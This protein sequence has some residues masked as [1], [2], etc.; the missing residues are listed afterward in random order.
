MLFATPA[1]AANNSAE[2]R[3]QLAAA[4]QAN[5]QHAVLELARRITSDTPKDSVTWEKLIRAGIALSEFDR[6]L[7][8][9]DEWERAVTP[10]P[11]VIE[12]LRG[13]ICLQNKDDAG[14]E[15]HWRNFVSA[16][17]SAAERA[18]TL[19]KLAD[20]C[21][22]QKRWVE[23]SDF[24]ARVVAARDTPANRV[25]LGTS[26]L[27]L[28]RWDAAAAELKR[29]NARDP[30]DET[31]KE[32]LPQFERLT[33]YLPRI[34]ALDAQLIK[35]PAN[36]PR[37]LD[38]ARLFTLAERPLLAL[39]DGERAVALQPR[40][41][42][43]RVQ[44]AEALLDDSRPDDATKLGIS[45]RLS[46]GPD[47]HVNERALDELSE[48]DAAIEQGPRN[49][50][51]LVARAKVLR[52][53]NQFTLALADAEAAIAIEPNAADAHF[54]AAHA[55][56]ELDRTREAVEQIRVAAALNGTDPVI[57]YYRGV[58]EAQRAD[59]VAAIDAQSHSIALRESIVALQERERCQRRLGK[60]AEADADL[61]RLE[62]LG[63]TK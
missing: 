30:S 14:A 27:R 6:A 52:G 38:R 9:L 60:T 49:A 37:L 28:H 20:L 18:T 22:D 12:D 54:E 42:R 36:V 7:V 43:A 24:R 45:S 44:T 11:A 56:D 59:F 32:W 3:A 51:A 8:S 58:L 21:V 31:V 47:H 48:R 15:T 10:H 53:L 41:M 39:D 23:S 25:M 34:K 46:R 2:L 19:T 5:D 29:A 13:D 62:K 50:P 26:L 17:V 40:S 16:K 33:K 1:A 55:L 63:I 4:T 61:Q 35:E 57:W